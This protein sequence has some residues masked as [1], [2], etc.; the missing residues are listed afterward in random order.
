MPNFQAYN[1]AHGEQMCYFQYWSTLMLTVLPARDRKEASGPVGLW[2]ALR[3]PAQ[4]ADPAAKESP[5][6]T[7]PPPRWSLGSVQD[8]AIQIHIK[9]I[10]TFAIY[11]SGTL[12]IK[13][14]IT[15]SV[16]SWTFSMMT[17]RPCGI[18]DSRTVA[19]RMES[20]HTYIPL[21]AVYS[22]WTMALPIQK[23]ISQRPAHT[24]REGQESL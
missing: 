7:S 12:A 24:G 5:Q 22:S 3:W 10:Y 4:K 16:H 13:I 15:M 18:Q 2:E 9:I 17:D 8:I 23:D 19:A 21:A 14:Y 20:Q 1:D 11:Y 6:L